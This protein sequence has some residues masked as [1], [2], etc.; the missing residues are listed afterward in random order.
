M[1][2]KIDFHIHTI[3]SHK[4]YDFSYSPKWL[5]RYVQEAELDAIAITNHD[6]F[7]KDNYYE[8]VE[9]L[10]DIKVFPGIELSLEDGHVNIVFDDDKIDELNYLSEYLKINNKSKISVNEYCEN[11]KSWRDGIYIFEHGKS[12]SLKIPKELSDVISVGGVS[13]QLRFQ[14]V[15]N[16]SNQITPVL[17]S[18]AHASDDDTEQDRNDINILKLKTTYLQIDNCRFDEIKKC[19]VD[20][21]KVS[22]NKK[23]LK[24]VIEIGDYIASTGLNLIIGRRG[25]GKTYFINSVKKYYNRDDIYEIAQFETAKADE[26]IEKQQKKQREVAI[27]KWRNTYLNQFK[28]IKDYLK[29]DENEFYNEVETFLESVKHFSHDFAKSQSSSKYKLLS[30][31]EFE[32]IT[33]DNFLNYLNKI[34]DLIN[35]NDLW[36][37]LKNAEIKK[38]E[39]IEIYRELRVIYIK[40]ETDRHIVEHSN[41]IISSVK[42]YLV[43]QTGI[44]KV[45]HCD[46]SKIIQKHQL[47]KNIVKFLNEIIIE[48]ELKKEN[49][50]GYNIVVTNKPFENASQFKNYLGTKEAVSEDVIKPYLNKDY[51][52]FLKNLNKKNFFNTDILEKCLVNMEVNL[53]DEDG[54]PA[55]GGQA[56]GF[57]LIMRLDEAKY[58]PIIL[59]DEPEASL[60]N[61]YI[62]NELIG[63]IKK[64]SRE[65]T[66]FVVTHNSTLGTLLDPDYL[67]VTSKD[68]NKDYQV[69]TG[70]F[71]S[72]L[73][74]NNKGIEE[75][76]FDKFVDAME[77]GIENYHK[78]GEIYEN[79]KN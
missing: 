3:S 18:D 14:Q 9:L 15:Y 22:V 57:S 5:K 67:I 48:K 6:L 26:Y 50:Y 65:S 31:N 17:F 1:V 39:L 58:K 35:A 53:L 41:D 42:D 45:Q 62:R 34:K 33:N 52:K 54:I 21:D 73:I 25:T 70:S 61:A 19:I 55:S 43:S 4:D 74:S 29:R 63:A 66:V 56:V 69:M 12:N 37:V 75:K 30:E 24:G 79:L 8:I 16:K 71:T 2:K 27:E 78:K 36:K 10:K 51:I 44:P 49:I 64:I 11:M 32:E 77:S 7:D 40:R 23:N 28:T 20:K 76:S 72:N 68:K 38:K 59:I 47:E 46:L 13:N 60:D